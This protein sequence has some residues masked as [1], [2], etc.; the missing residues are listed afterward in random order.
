MLSRVYCASTIGVDARLIEVETNMSSGVPKYFLVGLPDRAVSES[1]DRIEA[2]LKNSNAEFPNGRKTVNLAPADLPKEGSAFDLPIAI[3]LLHVSGQIH[4]DKLEDTLIL[5]ELA[6]DGQLRAVKGVLPM[7]VQ[8]RDKGLENMIVP[9]ENGPE[10][11]VVDGINVYSFE[12]IREVMEWLR[13][14]DTHNPLDV[15]VKKMFRRN[16]EGEI[17]D[18]SDVR[19]Q[20]AVKRALEVAAAGGHNVIT[21]YMV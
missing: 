2:A 19:G 20:E 11:A 4:T 6:L 9:A 16:G 3:T 5:G 18:F 7:A 1:R 14:E 13:D 10:A 21:I 8:A 15:N 17:L 12:N